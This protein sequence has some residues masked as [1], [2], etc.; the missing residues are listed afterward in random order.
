VLRVADAL[1]LERFHLLGMSQGGKLALHVAARWGDRVASLVL[2]GSAL[3]GVEA[4]DEAVPVA[5]MTAAARRGDLAGLRALWAG[6]PLL[7]LTGAAGTE[8]LAAMLA[9][10]DGR[11][12][13]AGRGQ[14]YGDAALLARVGAPV[15]A[16]VGAEDTPQRRAIV[17]ALGAQGAE[18][19][20]MAAAG[21][22]AS[23]DQPA[24]FNALLSDWWLRHG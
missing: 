7:R 24:S 4:A 12:L 16:V 14:L 15:L 9:D 19:R 13:L 20:V 18:T 2:Q 17:A 21:H 6:H 3:D 23:L 8:T 22:L 11:D 5:A 10:Y 1:G